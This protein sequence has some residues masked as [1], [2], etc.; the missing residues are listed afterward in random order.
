M[1]LPQQKSL[2][3]SVTAQLW[4]PPALTS[5]KRVSITMRV[6]AARSLK[7][8]VPSWPTELRP[9]QSTCPASC[10]AQECRSPAL[11]A[12]KVCAPVMSADSGAR[13]LPP[14][15]PTPSWPVLLE[16]QQATASDSSAQE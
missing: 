3:L 2:R 5:A 10:T 1:L 12:A 14:T 15:A 4:P 9:Q 16:P 6:G 7:S 8:P 11:T 13:K